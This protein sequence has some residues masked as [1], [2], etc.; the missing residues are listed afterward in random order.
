MQDTW[1]AKPYRQ[2]EKPLSKGRLSEFG[3]WHAKGPTFYWNKYVRCARRTAYTR[4]YL[5]HDDART[6]HWAM[7]TFVVHCYDVYLKEFILCLDSIVQV[8][9]HSAWQQQSCV[10][11]SSQ[12][13]ENA[14]LPITSDIWRALTQI[15]STKQIKKNQ[16]FF[17]SS[18]CCAALQAWVGNWVFFKRKHVQTLATQIFS[19]AFSWSLCH[20]SVKSLYVQ[21]WLCLCLD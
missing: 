20:T 1:T 7:S 15:W 17:N 12:A 4:E 3:P 6:K 5:A 14:M 13:Q 10:F 21:R 11:S 16:P 19:S 9:K 18:I 2:W 8:S